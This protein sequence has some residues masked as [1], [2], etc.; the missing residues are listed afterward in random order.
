MDYSLLLIKSRVVTP[1]VK[2]DKS[3]IAEQFLKIPAL[4]YVKSKQGPCQLEIRESITVP[5]LKEMERDGLK[6]RVVSLFM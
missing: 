3:T 2:S 5:A 4:V 1:M 6:P